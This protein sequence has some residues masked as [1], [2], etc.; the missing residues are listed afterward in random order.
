MQ[1]AQ[2]AECRY[3]AAL[4]VKTASHGGMKIRSKRSIY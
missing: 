3:C 4:K 2:A 1:L